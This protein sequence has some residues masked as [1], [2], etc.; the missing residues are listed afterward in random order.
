ML[1]GAEVSSEGSARGGSALSLTCVVVGGL[2]AGTPHHGLLH[3][4]PMH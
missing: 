2:L 1:A 3:R 4:L